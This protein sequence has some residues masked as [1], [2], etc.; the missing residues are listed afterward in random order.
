MA[1]QQE[2]WDGYSRLSSRLV[3]GTG[4]RLATVFSSLG[5]W[6]EDDYNRFVKYAARTVQG[7]KTQGARL[8]TA[9]YSEMAKT[10]GARFKAVPSNMLDLSTEVLRNGVTTAEVYRRPFVEVYTALAKGEQMT[11]AIARGA[12][13]VQSIA[14][15][16]VQLARREAGRQNRMSNQSIVGYRRVLTG[17]E[18]CALC[19]VAS[20]QRYT[21]SDLLPIHPGCDCGEMPIYGTQDPGQVL[22]QY[23]LDKAHELVQ[24]RFGVSDRGARDPIDYRDIKIQDHGELGPMLTIRG[25]KFTNQGDLLVGPRLPDENFYFDDFI[26][27]ESGRKPLGLAREVE[28]AA[29]EIEPEATRNMLD[30][31]DNVGAEMSGLKFRLKKRDSLA[32]KIR[33]DATEKRISQVVAAEE[34]G[35]SVRYTMVADEANYARMATEALDELEA[36]GY[37]AVKVKNYWQEGNA[38]QGINVNMLSPEGKKL[39]LQFHTYKSVKVK[40]PSHKLYEDARKLPNGPEKEALLKQGAELWDTVIM[41]PNTG[42]IGTPMY[43]RAG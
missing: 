23:N 30:V 7:A 11:D 32:R 41:P 20:T 4:S 6:R 29:R 28:S 13:R 24:Q 31:A 3:T 5:S 19:Y 40:E 42:G 2:L 25:Q 10:L 14:S 39:E 17:S 18:N 36:R 15:T 27:Q 16:D 21:K 8:Q 1:T 43:Q 9:Y 22:D 35:D 12:R 38:Y 33:T 34:I 37:R 26:I